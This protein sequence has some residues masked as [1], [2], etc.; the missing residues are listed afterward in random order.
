MTP[1]AVTSAEPP[2][3]Q[4]EY[5]AVAALTWMGAALA[6]IVLGTSSQPRSGAL[7][8]GSATPSTA[9][10][11]A[12]SEFTLA[13]LHGFEVVLYFYQHI[14]SDILRHCPEASRVLPVPL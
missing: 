14:T 6:V 9:L 11:V 7:P 2:R 10:P 5:S 13:R 3:P 12:P 4:W 1:P 8:V